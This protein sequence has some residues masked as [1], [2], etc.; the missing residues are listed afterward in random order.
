M[1]HLLVFLAI[2]GPGDWIALVMGS[3]TIISGFAVLIYKMGCIMTLIEGMKPDVSK[4]SSIQFNLD[5]M[6]PHTAKIPS[7][8]FKVEELWRQK[9]AKSGS[10]LVLNDYGKKILKDSNIEEFT[11]KERVHILEELKNRKPENAFQAQESLI[12]VLTEY[13]DKPEYKSYLEN[14]SYLSGADIMTILFAAAI[15]IRD[16]IL[17]ELNFKRDDIDSY[18]PKKKDTQSP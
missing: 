17:H 3:I 1:S 15:N 11:T 4:I 7:I 10:P 16:S 14:A 6:Q 8:E 12:E 13:K 2:F 18:D 9:I 5:A